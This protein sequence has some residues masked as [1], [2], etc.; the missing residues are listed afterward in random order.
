M[1][2]YRTPLYTTD[3]LLFAIREAA[4]TTPG[5]LTQAAYVRWLATRPPRAEPSRGIIVKRLGSWRAALQ[6]AGIPAPARSRPAGGRLAAD[7]PSAAVPA[8]SGGRQ[9][10]DAELVQ[11]LRAA[12]LATGR[13]ALTRLDYDGYRATLRRRAI[14]GSQTI[15]QRFG[16]WQAALERAGLVRR[17]QPVRQALRT[18]ATRALRLFAATRP[19]A[20]LTQARY[21]AFRHEIGAPLPSAGEISVAHGTWRDALAA[22]GIDAGARHREQLLGA[23]V[24]TAAFTA[25]GSVTFAT[26]QDRARRARLPSYR[27]FYRAFDSWPDAVAAAGL[28]S[29]RRRR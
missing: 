8:S 9:Y 11:S 14:A 20:R 1:S 27:T 15:D 13:A 3:D 16:S 7:N 29:P 28:A 26:Y 6:I 4:A 2:R 25:D 5:P 23:L 24:A 18:E 21:D 22:A 10:S 12:A 19:A 17:S